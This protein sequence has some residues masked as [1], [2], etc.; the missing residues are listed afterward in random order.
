[1]NF[2]SARLG[3]S[4]LTI[5]A[6]AGGCVPKVGGARPQI[7]AAKVVDAI[8]TDEV[9][10]NEDWKNGDAAKLAAH[11]AP[12][13]MVMMPGAAPIQ[14]QD[15][16]KQATQ[17]AIGDPAFTFTFASEK[18]DV[19]GSGDLAVSR[20]AFTETTTDPKTKAV[21]TTKGSFVTVYKPGPDGVWRATW[22]IATP[23]PAAGG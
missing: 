20:G 12:K 19:A 7:N 2:A 16:I 15:A 13:A 23:G 8:K 22:D 9:H 18:V 4:L 21:I 11:F 3:L 1:M 10:W 14:G 17:Q 5:A 6:I